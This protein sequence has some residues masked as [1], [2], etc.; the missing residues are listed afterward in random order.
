MA[1]SAEVWHGP[2]RVLKWEAGKCLYV[3]QRQ[4]REILVQQMT[5]LSAI[6]RI[7]LFVDD[8]EAWIV[9]WAEELRRQLRAGYHV[10]LLHQASELR[11]GDVCFLLGCTRILPPEMLALHRLNLVVHESA[12]PEGKGFAPVAWQILE[13]QNTIPVTLFEATAEPDA[14]PVYLRGAISLCGNELWPEIRALQGAKTVDMVLRF[15]KLWP[16]IAPAPQEGTETVY[17]R[18]TRADDELDVGKTLADQFD[19]LRIADNL[20]HPVWFRHRGR[21]Y[22]LR[23]E[24]LDASEE[25]KQ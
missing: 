15:L 20:R 12:L 25:T 6:K 9:P 1:L 7:T 2:L 14:G 16:R 22:A 10:A 17:P 5:E 3:E 4:G 18:R 24:P 19:H 11:P 23:I 13:G 21:G 8:P